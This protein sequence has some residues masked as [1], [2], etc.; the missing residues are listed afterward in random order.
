MPLESKTIVRTGDKRRRDDEV[1][2][3]DRPHQ[4]RRLHG[5]QHESDRPPSAVDFAALQARVDAIEKQFFN[6]CH[7]PNE[8]D[9]VLMLTPSDEMHIIDDQNSRPPLRALRR[10]T[11]SLPVHIKGAFPASAFLDGDRFHTEALLEELYR[12]NFSIPEAILSL[13]NESDKVKNSCDEY[14]KTIHIWFRFISAKKRLAAPFSENCEPD[15]VALAL[16]MRLMTSDPDDNT[17]SYLYK[18]TK[19]LLDTLVAR[20]VVS[21]PVLQAMIL[22]ALYEYCHAVYPAAWMSIGLCT[23]YIEL[24]G[25][26]WATRETV[27]HGSVDTVAL[28]KPIQWFET[29][30]E[31]RRRSWWAVFILDRLM[32]VGSKSPCAISRAQEHIKLPM[33]DDSWESLDYDVVGDHEYDWQPVVSAEHSGFS[34]LCEAALLIDSALILSRIEGTLDQVH[35][36]DI[37]SHSRKILSWIDTVDQESKSLTGTDLTLR[38]IGPRFA[39]RSALFLCVKKLTLR[40]KVTPDGTYLLK[41]HHGDKSESREMEKIEKCSARLVWQASLDIR[42]ISKALY[43]QLF[44]GNDPI[45]NLGIISPFILDGV[46]NASSNLHRL[47]EDGDSSQSDV[48]SLTTFLDELSMRWR[49]AREYRRLCENNVGNMPGLVE[50]S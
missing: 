47:S 33:H 9:E 49:S 37:I 21:L 40:A 26:S 8:Q 28:R 10:E 27:F 35:I 31:E 3:D 12:P 13:V 2:S 6:R 29:D 46:Y 38:L 16:A 4:L 18:Q 43:N 34:R 36:D 41:P 14:F 17:C 22:V 44:D 19:G 15:I 48:L 45:G 42:N 1:P 11:Q 5:S 25:V 7:I 24:V 23:R 32:S 50:K 20:G 30:E 39:A